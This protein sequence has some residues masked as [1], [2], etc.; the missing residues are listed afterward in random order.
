VKIKYQTL[1]N[2][3]RRFNDAD[4]YFINILLPKCYDI[5]ENVKFILICEYYS[6]Y[7]AFS[8]VSTECRWHLRLKYEQGYWLYA[9]AGVAVA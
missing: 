4:C 1:G 8:P 7:I 6:P 2:P 3:G 9:S 5:Y